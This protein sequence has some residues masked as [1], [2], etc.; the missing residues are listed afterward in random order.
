MRFSR[1]IAGTGSR[2][3]RDGHWLD[4]SFNL[5]ELLRHEAGELRDFVE[6]LRT[7]GFAAAPLLAP[8]DPIQEIWASGV[9]YL[10]SRVAREVESNSG[11]VYERVYAAERPEL[12]F[13]GIGWRAAGHNQSV[14]LRK[15]S[16]WNVPEP[17]LTLVVNRHG[18]IVGYTAGNDM[19]SRDIEG[20]N[21]LYLPQAKVFD[22]SSALGPGIEL[23]GA[24][25]LSDLPIGVELTRAHARVFYGETNS[26]QM[27][28]SL[29]ELVS[30]LFRELTFP[31]GVLLMTGTGIVPPDD[32][33]LQQG[34]VISIKVGA[35]SLVNRVGT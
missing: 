33:T 30:F 28:R 21:P 25:A 2:W 4:P 14:R 3:A 12:F 15:D 13:K 16:K 11:D 20:E 29:P 31:E 22:G 35:L 17:E 10:R 23:A 18:Q 24:S 34:D 19:S 32:F 1:H 27:R 26:S 7:F 9:T 5:A 8:I 6:G